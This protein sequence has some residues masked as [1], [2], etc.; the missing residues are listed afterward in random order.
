MHNCS[1]HLA[2]DLSPYVCIYPHCDTSDAMYVTTDD[3]KKHMKESHSVCRWICDACWFDSDEPTQFQYE[4]EQA[5]LDHIKT[6]HEDAFEDDDLPD[7]AEESQ[8]TALPPV[9]CPLCHGH[10]PLLNPETD[11]HIAEHLH[12]FSLQALPWEII[13]PDQD[14]QASVGSTA[15]QVLS[16]DDGEEAASEVEQ[17]DVGN[18][19]HLSLTEINSIATLCFDL[20][21]QTLPERARSEEAQL[22]KLNDTL[23]GLSWILQRISEMRDTYSSGVK[24]ELQTHLV[25]LKSVLQRRDAGDISDRGVEQLAILEQ[26]LEASVTFLREFGGV[27]EQPSKPAC[28]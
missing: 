11:K 1:G 19:G 5:W 24:G 10:T 14:T 2:E 3:W 20:M 25:H 27:G 12:S 15:H 8:R 28:R 16:L 7:L 9:Q 21:A 23:D 17:N 26:D 13:G 4:S 22:G 18:V 6:Q